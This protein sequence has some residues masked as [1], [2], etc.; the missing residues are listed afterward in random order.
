[1]AGTVLPPLEAVIRLH[2]KRSPVLLGAAHPLSEHL[3]DDAVIDGRRLLKP[4]ELLLGDAGELRRRVRREDV[5]DLV[6]PFDIEHHEVRQVLVV[7]V[8]GRPLVDAGR[9]EN[10]RERDDRVLHPSPARESP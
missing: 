3:V 8:P 1:M 7:E 9:R 6:G 4:R 10:P 5:A 2:E